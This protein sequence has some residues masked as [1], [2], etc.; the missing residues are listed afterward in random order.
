[1]LKIGHDTLKKRYEAAKY[2]ISRLR[3]LLHR[4]DETIAKLEKQL[5]EAKQATAPAIVYATQRRTCGCKHC[6]AVAN[7]SIKGGNYATR[8]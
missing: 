2:E 5:A 8:G 3:V 4:R 1:M 6:I 7:R